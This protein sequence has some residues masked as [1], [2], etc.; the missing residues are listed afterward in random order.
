MSPSVEAIIVSHVLVQLKNPET[1]AQGV[2]TLELLGKDKA[3]DI[4]MLLDKE[5]QTAVREFI[6]QGV[7]KRSKL[8]MLLDAAE[9]LK[10][11]M[12]LDVFGEV[13]GKINGRVASQILKLSLDDL[14]VVTRSLKSD[15]LPRFFL[16]L[17]PNKLA[18]VLSV[19][20]GK[21]EAR[22]VESLRA[23]PQVPQF[24]NQL[25][26]D[27][28]IL[29][30]LDKQVSIIE[31]DGHR[32]YLKWYKSIAESSDDDVADQMRSELIKSIP[33]M[34][35][36]V[37]EELI[38]FNTFFLLRTEIQEELIGGMSHKNIAALI[39]GLN[40]QQRAVILVLLDLRRQE[41]V[42]EELEAFRSRGQHQIKESH[43]QAKNLIVANMKALKGASSLM[44]FIDK[45]KNGVTNVATETKAPISS[46]VA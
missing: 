40:D 38:T 42:L 17:D 29:L 39:Q 46:H 5:S 35:H 20:K 43:R 19:L 1:V 3:N 21:D 33:Q 11:K 30:I 6:R 7:Y 45:S 27:R 12:L 4:F 41:L 24:E 14:V 28:D 8:H 15:V 36:Y 18:E 31:N 23:L 13:R 37:R 44:D 26:M 34:E 25:Q 16:Y 2:L 32:S 9:E 22:Y 10:T